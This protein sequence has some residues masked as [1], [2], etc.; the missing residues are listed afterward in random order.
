MSERNRKTSHIFLGLLLKTT[1]SEAAS[2]EV[3]E[4]KRTAEEQ[5]FRTIERIPRALEVRATRADTEE[6][7]RKTLLTWIAKDPHL[8]EGIVK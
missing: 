6:S 3:I 8:S 5:H 1:N 4:N 7:E 2:G